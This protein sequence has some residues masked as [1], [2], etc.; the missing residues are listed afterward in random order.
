MV[1]A[2]SLCSDLR[3]PFLDG[4]APGEQASVGRDGQAPVAQLLVPALLGGRLGEP[5]PCLDEAMPWAT[6]A[7][8][9]LAVSAGSFWRREPEAALRA[10]TK[11]FSPAATRDS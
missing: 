8:G 7:R 2:V 4:L 9:R 6:I 11:A 5:F 10:F 1:E 3:D